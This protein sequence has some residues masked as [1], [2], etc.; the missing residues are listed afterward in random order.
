MFGMPGLGGQ[1][2]SLLSGFFKEGGI[3]GSAVSHGMAPMSAFNNAPRL[4]VGTPNISSGEHPAILHDDEA[5]IPLSRGR[6]VPV[7]MRGGEAKGGST[8][9]QNV[10]FNIQAKDPNEFRRS[11]HQLKARAVRSLGSAA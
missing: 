8:T 3:T 4:A 9:N 2:G 10:V 1:I 5:V 7:Q 11:E 6:Y